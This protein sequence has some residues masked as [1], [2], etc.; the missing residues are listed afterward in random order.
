MC[1]SRGA[2]GDA[3]CQRR[4][5]LP[6]LRRM[7]A[8]PLFLTLCGCVWATF[9]TPEARAFGIFNNTGLNGGSRWDAA[10]RTLGGQERSLDGGLRFSLQ[11]GSYQA[12]RDLFTWATV[13]SVSDFEQAVLDAFAV[14]MATDAGSGLSTSL[15]F[16]PD[17]STAVSTSLVGGVRLGAEIDL[18]ASTDGGSWNPGDPGTR[19]EA[20]FN[21]VSVPGDLTLTSGTTNYAGFAIS[22]SDITFNNNPTA[23]YTLTTFRTILA[24]EI[25]HSLGLADVDVTSG[26][27]GTFIDDNYDGATAATALATLTNS[28]AATIDPLDPWATPGLSFYTVANGTPGVDTPGVDILMESAIPSA[29]FG[30][31]LALQNDDAAGRQFLY[32]VPEPAG[33][34]LAAFGGGLLSLRRRRS[35]RS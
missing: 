11:G 1:N 24:H 34:T 25:G 8:S 32:P 15:Y 6:T 33:A 28:W 26:P 18:F 27:A 35:A 13:P 4:R 2:A 22:G 10:P 16:V 17:L 5:A 23:V 29:L 21:S 12:Y 20:F 7:K 31:S 9:A 30:P 19:A 14:W 3:S